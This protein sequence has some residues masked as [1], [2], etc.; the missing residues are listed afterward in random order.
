MSGLPPLD[1][2]NPTLVL[3]GI[4]AA[5]LIVINPVA[6]ATD[7]LILDVAFHVGGNLAQAFKDYQDANNAPLPYNVEIFYESIGELSGPVTAPFKDEGTWGTIS[8]DSSEG[9]D[10]SP[11]PLTGVLFAYEKANASLPAIPNM[12]AGAYK[13]SMAVTFPTVPLFQ[14]FYAV[15]EGPIIRRT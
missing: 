14:A 10:V 1:P 9:V 2:S 12:R 7:P 13:L 4:E 5:K 8:G 3:I 15:L 6:K 11:A